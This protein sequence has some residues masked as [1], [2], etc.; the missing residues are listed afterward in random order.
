MKIEKNVMYLSTSE[1]T[2]NEN[3]D[4][5]EKLSWNWKDLNKE[6]TKFISQAN[7]YLKNKNKP[8]FKA[9]QLVYNLAKIVRSDPKLSPSSYPKNHKYKEAVKLYK[10]LDLIA[11][12]FVLL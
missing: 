7:K 2:P 4:L 9:K 11:T 6:Y 3:K 5:I 1:L 12:R 10:S 8:R